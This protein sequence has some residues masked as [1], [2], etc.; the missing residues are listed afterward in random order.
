[1][2]CM[3]SLSTPFIGAVAAS[4]TS[5]FGSALKPNHSHQL[6][7]HQTSNVHRLQIRRSLV[8]PRLDEAE[9]QLQDQPERAIQGPAIHQV[10]EEDVHL[11][12]HH[13]RGGL[14]QLQHVRVVRLRA[15]GEGVDVFHEY[16]NDPYVFSGWELVELQHLQGKF[17]S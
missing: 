5:G 12:L 11:P 10:A 2:N 14:P 1:M 17:G 6:Q 15:R 16:S 9:P 13:R 4:S 3:C 7:Q 8:P